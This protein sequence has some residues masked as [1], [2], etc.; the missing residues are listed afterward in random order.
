MNHLKSLSFIRRSFLLIGLSVLLPAV[1]SA[2]SYR[3]LSERAVQA[4]EH[5]SLQLAETLL[6]EALK[7]EPANPHN[8]LLFS[9]LGTIQ[10]RQKK[11]EQALESYNYALN[12]APRTVPI[13]LNR[14]T[15]YLELGKNDAA[16]A[17]YSLVLDA[18]PDHAEAL[19]MRAYIYMQHRDYAWARADYNRLLKAHPTDF[20]ARL[21]L[22]TLAQKEGKLEEAFGILN[23]LVQAEAESTH[24]DAHQ[25]SLLYVARAGVEKDLKHTD[26]ALLDLEEAL[27]LN[28]SQAEAYLMRVQIYLTQGK[29][30]LAKDDL[31]QAMALG[32]PQAEIR[33]LWKQ[34]K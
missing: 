4:T 28:P 23:R 11:Y 22:A 17:D 24:P 34:C 15:L 31:T 9:N 10:R 13:L 6:R 3:E 26:L 2:Q 20:K 18:D 7:L 16:R 14:A 33:D 29:K 8:A 30:R 21:G 32:V 25:L 19:L 27:R 1:L 12:I 5:D